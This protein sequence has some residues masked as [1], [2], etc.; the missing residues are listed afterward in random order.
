M[1][2]ME[3]INCVTLQNCHNLEKKIKVCFIRFKLRT[4]CVQKGLNK[5]IYDSKTMAMYTTTK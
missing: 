2:K 5:P 3:G 4:S 1:T